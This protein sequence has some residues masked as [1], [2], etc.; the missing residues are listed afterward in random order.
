MWLLAGA[1][2]CGWGLNGV[3][4]C[5]FA[6]LRV[7]ALNKDTRL[8]A[9]TALSMLVNTAPQPQ[10]GASA[11]LTLFQLPSRGACSILSWGQ[12]LACLGVRGQR[13]V[14]SWALLLCLSLGVWELQ[15]SPAASHGHSGMSHG[16]CCQSSI[17]FCTF[18]PSSAAIFQQALGS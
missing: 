16:S 6:S 17:W 8:L 10:D 11:V 13:L 7:Q 12:P 4:S 5:A 18:L 3:L 1:V 15:L 14:P 2:K 9:G